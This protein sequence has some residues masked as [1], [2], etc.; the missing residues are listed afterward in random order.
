MQNASR[1]NVIGRFFSG[2]GFLWKGFAYWGRR[3]S[4]MALGAVPALVVGAVIVAA[5]VTLGFFLDD[6]AALV[7][8]FADSWAEMYRDALRLAVGAA[9]LVAAVLLVVVTFTAATLAVGDPIYERI[10]LRVERDLGGFDAPV[11]LPFWAGV[12][13][14]TASGLRLVGFTVIAGVVVFAIGLIP[15]VGAVLGPACGWMVGGWAVARELLS[16]PVDAR[17]LDRRA[18]AVMRAANRPVVLGFGLMVYVVFLIPFAAIVAMPA[19]VVGSTMLFR[20]LVGRIG[21]S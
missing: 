9:I 7:T 17:A 15:V 16:R 20:K 1:P 13:R 11:E 12:R 6:L 19:A 10:W 21:N 3:P 5:L 8:P 2:V 4:L 18:E 14:A